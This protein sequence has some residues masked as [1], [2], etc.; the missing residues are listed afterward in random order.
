MPIETPK[1]LMCN[2]MVIDSPMLLSLAT[3]PFTGFPQLKITLNTQK[4]QIYGNQLFNQYSDTLT[5][6]GF[7]VQ[8]KKY[9]EIELL[10]CSFI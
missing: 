10:M 5:H 2:T 9:F 6:Y 4:P 8:C 1:G 3:F 7:N